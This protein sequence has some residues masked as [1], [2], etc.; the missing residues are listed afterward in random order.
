MRNQKHERGGSIGWS[1]LQDPPLTGLSSPKRERERARDQKERESQDPKSRFFFADKRR[2]RSAHLARTPRLRWLLK[3]DPYLSFY[4]DTHVEPM[5][6][7]GHNASFVRIG[8]FWVEDRG[9]LLL[10]RRLPSPAL[11]FY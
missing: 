7:C 10:Q 2:R 5:P 9:G 11:E 1:A 8:L 4:A 3:M 6:F